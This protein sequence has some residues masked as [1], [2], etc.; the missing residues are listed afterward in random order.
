MQEHKYKSTVSLLQE[1]LSG[2]FDFLI[3]NKNLADILKEL[4]VN[5]K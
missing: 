1:M 3:N 2:K 5:L 4:N